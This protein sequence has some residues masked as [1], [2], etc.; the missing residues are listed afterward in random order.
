MDFPSGLDGKEPTCNVGDWVRSLGGDDP[1]EEGKGTHSSIL[2]TWC[3]E[4]THQKY[5]AGKY[6]GE[7]DKEA[8]EDEMFKQHHQVNGHEFEQTLGDNEGWRSLVEAV[9]P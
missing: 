6:S 2:A 7:E 1:L 8:T 9:K 5:C 4:L 3:E